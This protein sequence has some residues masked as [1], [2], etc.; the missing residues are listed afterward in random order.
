MTN[1]ERAPTHTESDASA[2]ERLIAVR[3][4]GRPPNGPGWQVRVVPNKFPA[5]RVEGELGKSGI[6]L[7]DRM[8]GVGA[9]EII[10]RCESVIGGDGRG[11][12]QPP[13]R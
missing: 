6:G 13:T 5:L 1:Q 2:R 8:N 12:S 3:E 9:H 4:P 11:S 10:S 7:Y